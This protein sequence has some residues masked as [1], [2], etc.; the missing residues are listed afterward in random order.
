M[1]AGIPLRIWRSVRVRFTEHTTATCGIPRVLL[2]RATGQVSL[3]PL[4]GAGDY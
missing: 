1:P 3:L 4:A 2:F